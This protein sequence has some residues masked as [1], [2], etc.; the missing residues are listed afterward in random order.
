MGPPTNTG[1]QGLAGRVPLSGVGSQG[2]PVII[3]HWSGV[4]GSGRAICQSNQIPFL[5]VHGQM[6]QARPAEIS[7]GVE[8]LG[9]PPQAGPTS[10]APWRF[11]TLAMR[12]AGRLRP[13]LVGFRA[14][15]GSTLVAQRRLYIFL[16]ININMLEH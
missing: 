2:H 7:G 8:G 12:P 1:P 13:G 10:G 9:S 14:V 5:C 6:G 15:F 11:P 4:L 3:I 16:V